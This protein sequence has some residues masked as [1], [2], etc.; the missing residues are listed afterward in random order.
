MNGPGASDADVRAWLEQFGSCVRERD[1]ARARALFATDCFSFGTRVVQTNGIAD[2]VENQWQPIWEVTHGFEIDPETVR[3]SRADDGS[4]TLVAARWSS[5]SGAR[6]RKGRCT[7]ALRP[8]PDG[9]GLTAIHSHFS[10]DPEWI[11]DP[12]R[13]PQG[14]DWRGPSAD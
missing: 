1:T 5:S 2:L 6:A 9:I 11:A 14:D 8:A 7:I 4:L 10:L 12:A 13:E 3:T